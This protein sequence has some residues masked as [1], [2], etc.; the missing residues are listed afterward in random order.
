MW[1][2]LEIL[3]AGLIVMLNAG[4]T[5]IRLI[6]TKFGKHMEAND[7]LFYAIYN[8]ILRYFSKYLVWSVYIL[9]WSK[10]NKIQN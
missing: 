2:V 6:K 3:Y 10:S 9:F 5:E 1:L 7:N 4:F 8:L